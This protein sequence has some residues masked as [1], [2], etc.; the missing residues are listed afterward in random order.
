[1][2]IPIYGAKQRQARIPAEYQEVEYLSANGTQYIDTGVKPG[3]DYGLKV[4][5]KL[6]DNVSYTG[7]Q[8]VVG[9]LDDNNTHYWGFTSNSSNGYVYWN[10]NVQISGYGTATLLKKITNITVNYYNDKKCYINGQQMATLSNVTWSNTYTARLFNLNPGVQSYNYKFLGYIYYSE[11]TYQNSLYRKYIPC[12]RKSD[13]KPGF[14]ETETNTFLTNSGTGEFGV[15]PEVYYYLPGNIMSIKNA[16]DANLQLA[17]IGNILPTKEDGLIFSL[18]LQF[19]G[20]DD[21]SGRTPSSYKCQFLGD[22]NADMG[23]AMF[24]DRSF[25]LYDLLPSLTKSIKTIYFEYNTA[26]ISSNYRNLFQLA[27]NNLNRTCIG[28]ALSSSYYSTIYTAT[29]GSTTQVT[30]LSNSHS[31]GYWNKAIILIDGTTIYF[32]ENGTLQTTITTSSNVFGDETSY[33]LRFGGA[34]SSASQDWNGYIRNFKLYNKVF[35]SQE[36]IDMT[37]TVNPETPANMQK[38]VG[39]RYVTTANGTPNARLNTGII[40]TLDYLIETE[41]RFLNI[42]FTQCIFCSRGAG[43]S[44][45]EFV[46]FLTA[47][48]NSDI[49]VDLGTSQSH[50]PFWPNVNEKLH[51]LYGRGICKINDYV[52]TLPSGQTLSNNGAI[53]L[54]GSYTYSGGTYSN[55]GNQAS[56]DMFYFKIWDNNDNLVRDYIPMW[57]YTASANGLYDKVNSNFVS[58]EGSVAFTYTPGDRH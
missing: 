31:R 28:Y 41:V 44:E 36:M 33:K 19:D 30:T 5:F 13:R 24:G 52:F 2:K 11:F 23:A 27:D 48:N 25:L 58:S 32:Y 47:D 54:F 12:Y 43:Y 57:S 3:N 53:K 38:R 7:G 16:S 50:L 14:Y 20:V 18:P 39:L 26:T 6:C 22:N 1:M 10:G 8:T 46:I 15:G 35:T 17:T 45:N 55:Y 9:V 4:I 34:F 51:I 42:G 40:P 21:I 56:M 37:T 29:P 49:R